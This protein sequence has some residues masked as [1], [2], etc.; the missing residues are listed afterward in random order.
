MLTPPSGLGVSP[1]DMTQNRIN[2]SDRR[3]SPTVYEDMISVLISR[4]HPEAQRVDGSGGDGGRDVQLPQPA[5]LEIF[6][7]KSFT[8]RMNSTRRRQVEKSLK[9]AAEHNPK[10]WHLVV[11]IN[12]NPSEVEWFEK[13]TGNYLFTC[14]WLGMDWLD[15]HMASHPELLRYYID[16]SSDEIVRALLEL[17]K[18]QAYLTGG[19]PDAID[20]ISALTARLNE[21]DPHYMFALSASPVDG[22]KVAVV[23]RYPGAEKDRP[24]RLRAAFDFPDTD[25]GRAAAA[26][27]SATVAYGTACEIAE[28]FVTNVTVEGI[29]G[30]DSAFTAPKLAFGPGQDPNL[31]MVP[32]IALRLI[33]ANG[34]V[35]FQLPLK[36]KGRTVGLNGGEL[37]LTDYAE[38][39]DVRMRFNVS[40]RRFALNYHFSTPPN[41]L[42]GAL[43]P[44]LRFLSGMRSG[45]LAAVLFNNQPVGPPATSTPNIPDELNGYLRL[46]TDLDEIQRKSTIYFPMPSSLSGDEQDNILMARQ[47]VDGET[48]S[49]EWESSKMT[50][51]A[52]SLDGLRSL[53]EEGG[54]KIWARVP[55]ILNL[56][57]SEYPIGYVLRTHGSAHIPEWPTVPD[58]TAPDTDIEVSLLPGSDKSVTIKM[59]TTEELESSTG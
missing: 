12:H 48:V 54:Q 16:G 3:I 30:L 57:G 15:G 1:A 7:L 5:G 34:A 28:E 2:W 33:R 39:V 14:D 24:I 19:L 26:A 20:R 31:P 32:E 50:M 11:P 56:E 6:E 18:E 59:L 29:A 9:R 47:L 42:P 53:A 41:I 45:H 4:I 35:A 43:V 23:P 21:L 46:A 58:G 51:P 13:A 38:V 44:A 52:R 27:L 36:L 40:T 22:V 37:T 10:A 17:N 55:F 25:E 49:A 8:G